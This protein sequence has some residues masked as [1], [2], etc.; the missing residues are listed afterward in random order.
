MERKYLVKKDPHDHRDFVYAAPRLKAL[1]PYVDLRGLMSP[2]F[3]QLN[4]GACLPSSI[5]R[6]LRE[7]YM[8]ANG[9]KYVP[10]ATMYL[11]YKIRELEGTINE[12]AGGYIRDGMKAATTIG[13]CPEALWPYI[14]SKFTQKP[15]AEADAAA[16]A[17]KLD[18]YYRVYG[19]TNIKTVL[20]EGKPVVM[21]I[22]IYTSF[23][24]QAVADTG[25][26][27]LPDKAK[28]EFL[29]GHAVL[30]VGYDDTK[31]R[32]IVRNSWGPEWGDKGYFYLS[33]DFVEDSNLVWDTWVGEYTAPVPTN[34]WDGITVSEAIDYLTGLSFSDGQPVSDSPDF[35]KN[36]VAKY[37][38]E[39]DS[40][41]RY[42][43]LFLR[44]LAA[45]MQGK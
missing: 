8:I 9:Q 36:L 12:D 19:L 43:G 42:F 25:V 26:V 14:T 3:N 16:V 17:Y 23:E 40:D 24:S 15:P 5:A 39:G 31:K 4:I 41:F 13:I 1:P 38:E 35:W 32:L 29:G 45:K 34:P 6:G 30:A 11:Y 27:P 20:A 28:E 44:K 18:S 21:G 37:P 22:A 33:Y 10:L 7:H 2:V